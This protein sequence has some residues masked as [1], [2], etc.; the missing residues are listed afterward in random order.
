MV[1]SVF[2]FREQ[3]RSDSQNVTNGWTD[4]LVANAR[5]AKSGL[6]WHGVFRFWEPFGSDLQNVIDGR[7]DRHSH[8]KCHT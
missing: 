7:T 8:S 5:I 1:L 3:F 6:L 4:I 2:R